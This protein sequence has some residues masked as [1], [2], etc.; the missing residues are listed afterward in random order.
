VPGCFDDALRTGYSAPANVVL[1]FAN[2]E[3][4]TEAKLFMLAVPDAV[5]SI[6]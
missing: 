1:M 5:P 2:E 4:M 6:K 3:L